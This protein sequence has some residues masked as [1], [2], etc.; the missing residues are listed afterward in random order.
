MKN[1]FKLKELSEKEKAELVTL[2]NALEQTV[3]NLGFAYEKANVN[4]EKYYRSFLD[5]AFISF[6]I[7]K[8]HAKKILKIAKKL[9]TIIHSTHS[10][11]KI[12]A[13]EEWAF[14]M[15]KSIE[16]AIIGQTRPIIEL[17]SVDFNAKRKISSSC[18]DLINNLKVIYHSINGLIK[19]DEALASEE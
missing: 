10:N 13:E 14:A 2:A 11:K 9:E 19:I 8:R 6:G 1:P 3:T 7:A 5:S 16:A 18:I 17:R 4:N 12:R 15:S